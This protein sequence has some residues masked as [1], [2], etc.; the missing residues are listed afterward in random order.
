MYECKNIDL[1][2][3]HLCKE[4]YTKPLGIIPLQNN[5]PKNMRNMKNKSLIYEPNYCNIDRVQHSKEMIRI[6]SLTA[7]A[8]CSEKNSKGYY[9]NTSNEC[10]SLWN[11]I[12]EYATYL[13]EQNVLHNEE[14][15]DLD[16]FLESL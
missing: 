7:K 16:D 5:I 12:L 6:H 13:E 15:S 1:K 4:M 11:E 2:Q 14:F 8:F 9:C 10:V 3:I